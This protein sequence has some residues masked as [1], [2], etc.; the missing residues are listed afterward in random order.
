MKDT[1]GGWLSLFRLIGEIKNS[2]HEAEYDLNNALAKVSE[3][4]NYV[5]SLETD[6]TYKYNLESTPKDISSD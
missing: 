2:C 5:K 4:S 3:L 6:L 1:I